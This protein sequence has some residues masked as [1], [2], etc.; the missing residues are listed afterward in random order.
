MKKLLLVIICFLFLGVGKQTDFWVIAEIDGI[1]TIKVKR[2]FYYEY[3]ELSMQTQKDIR[4]RDRK[5]HNDSLAYEK[6]E[7]VEKAEN[8]K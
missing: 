4:K 1:A 7:Q 8:R 5:F 2:D 6:W 3:L